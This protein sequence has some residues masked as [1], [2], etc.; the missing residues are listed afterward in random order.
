MERGPPQQAK[1]L[2]RANPFDKCMQKSMELMPIK[3]N[4]PFTPR[5][6]GNAGL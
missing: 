5:L 2:D 6:F 1:Y 4:P 3:D